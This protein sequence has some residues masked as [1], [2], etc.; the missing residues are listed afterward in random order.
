M[1]AGDG[2]AKETTWTIAS[3][4]AAQNP[5][6]VYNVYFYDS[7]AGGGVN[8]NHAIVSPVGKTGTGL[9]IDLKVGDF[10]PLKLTGAN[11]LIGTRAGQTVGHYI[12]L[13]SLAPDAS[14]FKLYDTSLARAIAKCGTVCDS[15]PAG[16]TGEDKLEKYIADNLLPVGG[17]RLRS[18]RGRRRRRGHVR[19]AGT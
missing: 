11:G 16:G 4:F 13:I 9:S 17:S 3:T 18:R 6:R 19:P 5:S 14:Q 2:T 1:P 10:L 12:K 15:L 7:V 8:Y